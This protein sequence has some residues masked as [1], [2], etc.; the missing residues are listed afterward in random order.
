M[1]GDPPPSI[2]NELI[3]KITINQS[4]AYNKKL[5]QSKT[6]WLK[7]AADVKSY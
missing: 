6:S 3:L 7:F 1:R 5:L 2:F 4:L